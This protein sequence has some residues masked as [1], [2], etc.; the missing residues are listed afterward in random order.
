VVVSQPTFFVITLFDGKH[1]LLDIKAEYMRKYGEMLFTENLEEIVK[2]LDD[3]YLLE[4]ERYEAYRREMEDEFRKADLRPAIFAGKSYESDS[5]KLMQQLE[6]YF[7]SPQGPGKSVDGQ[8]DKPIKGI[9]APH[10]DFQ[11]GGPCYAWAYKELAES[12]SPDLFIILG[13]VHHPTQNPFVLTR[14]DFETPLGRVETEKNIIESLE[15]KVQF[16][17]FQDEIVQKA[18]HSIEFQVIFL[19]YLYRDRKPFKIVPILCSS[20]QD[21]ITQDNGPQQKPHLSDFVN[22]LSEKVTESDYQTCFIASADLAHVG[23]RFGDPSPPSSASLQF[24]ADEDRKMLS[25]VERMDADGFYQFIQ[26]EKDSRKIC[27]LPPIYT[28]LRVMNTGEGKL[29]NYQQSVEP[30]GS[31]VVTFASMVFS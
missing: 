13:T 21:V 7:V 28:L 19:K 27:G 6:T 22:A 20:F 16:D 24:I 2:Q 8:T 10:I 18:E 1:S 25:Y 31:S 5:Q 26:R 29:L 9:I 15:K 14:K 12:L 17:L 30:N 4:N 3:N 11:R 23:T